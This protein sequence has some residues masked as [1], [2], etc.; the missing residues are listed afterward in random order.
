[1]VGSKSEHTNKGQ[2]VYAGAEHQSA[3]SIGRLG[4]RRSCPRE[5][6]DLRA[7]FWLS[8]ASQLHLIVGGNL[9][10][11]GSLVLPDGDK[12]LGITSGFGVDYPYRNR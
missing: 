7:K 3:G 5:V 11:S 8:G 6:L 10:I 1:M 2:L 12:A 4:F 9:K